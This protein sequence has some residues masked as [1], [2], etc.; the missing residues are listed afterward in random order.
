[1]SAS[2]TPDKMH[3]EDG[4]QGEHNLNDLPQKEEARPAP[5]AMP[6]FPEG[7]SKAW[8]VVFGCWC[9]SFASFGIVNSFG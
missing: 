3:T 6:I 8:G 7:G 5:T 2:L 4:S 1:M 9:T